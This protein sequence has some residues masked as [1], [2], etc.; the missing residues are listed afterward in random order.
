MQIE[1]A[2]EN[3]KLSKSTFLFGAEQT[4]VNIEDLDTVLNEL[5]EQTGANKELNKVLIYFKAI[6]NEMADYIAGLDVDEDICKNIEHCASDKKLCRECIKE[7][8]Y[9]KHKNSAK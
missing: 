7:Y 1:E 9:K 3:I 8:F 6:I 2:I 4:I 5:E